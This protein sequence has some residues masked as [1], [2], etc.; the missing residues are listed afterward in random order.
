MGEQVDHPAHYTHGAIECI[1]AIEAALG[2]DG[3][4]AWLRG[5][6][7]KYQWRL[8]HKD[9]PAQDAA[10]AEWYSRRLTAALQRREARHG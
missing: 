6:I 7:I 1:D 8:G 3:F 2:P 5:T 10:K 4:V 9:A